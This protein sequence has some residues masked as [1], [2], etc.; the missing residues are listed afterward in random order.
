[1]KRL[2]EILKEIESKPTPKVTTKKTIYQPKFSRKILLLGILTGATITTI[3]GGLFFII[4]QETTLLQQKQVYPTLENPVVSSQVVEAKHTMQNQ[5]FLT[6]TPETVD[7]EPSATN[8]PEFTATVQP[9]YT[10]LPTYKTYPTNTPIPTIPLPTN[11]LIPTNT[12]KPD[13]YSISLHLDE[14]H[15]A[16]EYCGS[17]KLIANLPP[18]RNVD[19]LLNVVQGDS[20]MFL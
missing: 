2:D 4:S 18:N 3:C 17:A 6:N 7:S 12:P 15:S 20:S 9:T 13:P 5:E 1:M 14:G 19:V 11:T 10:A 8:T 16:Y